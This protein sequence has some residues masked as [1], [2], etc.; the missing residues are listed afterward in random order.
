[1]PLSTAEVQ[2]RRTARLLHWGMALA[3]LAMI[4]A[5][6]V[7]V[8][9]GLD[10][11][12]QNALFLF[13]KNMGVVLLGLVVV[14]AVYRWWCPPAPLPES[15]SALQVRIAGLSH[16]ALYALLFVVPVAGYV[17]VKA[18]G[19]PIESLDWLGVPSL[20]P[21]SDALAEIAKSIH[22]FGGIALAALIG[23]HVAAAAYHGI[24]RRDGVFSRMWPPFSGR[25]AG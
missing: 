19:F 22:Y 10:R 5:G 18:G 14:R 25:R 1:M 15:M 7:M 4:P 13:H 2:Y 20:V 3:V 23:L 11:S 12:L 6:L 9:S 21:R 8:Q 16:R 24:I 17:R